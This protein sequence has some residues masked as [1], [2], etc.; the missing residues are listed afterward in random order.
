MSVRRVLFTIC[1]IPLGMIA[2]S[3]TRESGSLPQE[4]VAPTEE[5]EKWNTANDPRRLDATFIVELD[6]LPKSGEVANLP[7]PST[8]WPIYQDSINA[9]WDGADSLS[10]AEKFEKAF[11]RPGFSKT[12]QD[13]VGIKAWSR[14]KACKSDKDCSGLEDGSACA[15]P[16]NL[17]TGKPEAGGYCIPTWFGI[18]PGWADFANREPAPIKPV[19]ING[20]TFYPADVEALGALLYDKGV[21]SAKFISSRCNM[22]EEDMSSAVDEFG[23]IQADECRDMNPGTFHVINANMIGI[24]KANYVIER[25]SHAE[26][27]NQ[28]VRGYDVKRQEAISKEEAVTLLSLNMAFSE[29][30][31]KILIKKGDTREGVYKATTAGELVIKMHG[32]GDADL[33]VRIGGRANS[34]SNDCASAG[35]SSAE[36]C[37]VNV[38]AGDEVSYAVIGYG[39][40]ST[41][42]LSI[43]GKKPGKTDYIFNTDAVK[44]YHVKTDFKWI[45]ESEASRTSSLSAIDDFTRTDNLEYIL[46]VDGLGRIMGGEWIGKSKINHPDF[47]WWGISTPGSIFGGMLTYSDVKQL[48]DKAKATAVQPPAPPVQPPAP[49]VQPPAPTAVVLDVIEHGFIG[50]SRAEFGT[51][52]LVKG[53]RVKFALHGEGKA[54][55]AVVGPNGGLVCRTERERLEVGALPVTCDATADQTGNYTVRVKGRPG[56]RITVKASVVRR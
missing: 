32:D 43:G 35:N 10:P 19:E 2:C 30:L 25:T 48:V 1:S 36:E 22:T 26:V 50:R 9:R 38:K 24:R 18:C 51:V 45:T 41:I 27:W 37:R 40:T 44:F 28:P 54:S 23:R 16:R 55:M 29:V 52:T 12:V 13:K 53:D 33:Y 49:P 15:I 4:P 46:E 42:S 31:A 20:I 47:A 39:E 7:V 6:K 14:N 8:Y 56:T 21:K 11:N 3:S 17:D 34:N 5:A